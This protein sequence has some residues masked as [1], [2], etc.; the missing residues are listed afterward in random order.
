MIE[1]ALRAIAEPHR[2]QIL[3]LVLEQE[4][5]AGDIASHF[6]VTRP[7]IS[8]HLRVLQDAGLLDVRKE[9]A[10]RMYH[11]RSAGME[12]L[13]ASLSDFWEGGL[14]RLK[15]VAENAGQAPDTGTGTGREH[16][17]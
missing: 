16:A 8:Q 1:E 10:R 9:G 14:A 5:S 2:R 12:E 7:A 13:R 17:R 15:V 4:R 11:V 3:K 6:D